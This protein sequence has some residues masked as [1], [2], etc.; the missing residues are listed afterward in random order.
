MK[1]YWWPEV[2]RDIGKYVDSCDMCQRMKNWTKTPVEKLKSSKV[3][4]K[5]WKHLT[6]DFIT[7]LPLV[8]GKNMILVVYDRLSKMIHFMVTIEG[9]SAERLARL[10]RDNVWKLYKL[11]E[12]VVLN[13][14]LQFTV[15]LTKEL[16]RILEIKTK[17]FISLH[18][19]TDRQTEQMNQKLEQYLEFFVDYKQKDWPKWL[20]SAEFSVNN[21]VYLVT[22]MS[23]F[24][25][26]HS[27]KLRMEVDI[28]R[29]EKQKKQQSLWKE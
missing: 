5:L 15:D 27:K 29:K 12:S 4:K 8:A 18:P 13:R 2:T 3:L 22:K 1:N 20:T 28:K 14:G 9:I 21:K 25:A 7:K 6:I 23:L 24:M 10:F 19:Q 16:N 11:L 17:L 26:N